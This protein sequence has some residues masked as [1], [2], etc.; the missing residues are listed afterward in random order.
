MAKNTNFRFPMEATMTLKLS[1]AWLVRQALALTVL[2]VGDAAGPSG[3]A[4]AQADS[5][6]TRINAEAATSDI[7][8]QPLRGNVSAV[9]GSG[10]NI[11]VLKGDD[12]KLMVD[13]GIMLSRAKLSAALDSISVAPPKYA[14][15][16]HWHWDHTSGNEWIHQ[17]GATIIAHE[18]TAKHLAAR[19]RVEDWQYTFDPSPEG[20]LPTLIVR[21]DLTLNFGNENVLIRSYS[22]AHTDGDLY[23]YFAK[24]DVLA[25]GDT[26]WNGL[27]PFIDTGAGGGIDGMIQAANANIALA[28]DKTIVV[29]G[30]GP[31][32]G[33]AQLI[34]YRDMLVG[35]RDNV[36]ALK[37]QGKS[38][39][40][41]IAAKPTAAYDTKW[42]SFVIDPAFFTRLVYNSL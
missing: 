41:V 10:G 24:A 40:E 38:L 12:G 5:P 25:T 8:V 20:A 34:E 37:K 17:A 3:Q 28:T 33:R 22:P 14:I 32:S 23:V 11:T 16:T 1:S 27:Y 2:A 13:T 39:G 36:A 35:I 9:M 19:I 7:T 26:Y 15:N 21:T 18:K 30:H 31:V 4:L 6:V 29:P 42:G